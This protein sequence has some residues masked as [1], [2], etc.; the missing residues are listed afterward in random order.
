MPEGY[1]RRTQGI[2]PFVRV[3]MGESTC[4]DSTVTL[5]VTWI[6]MLGYPPVTC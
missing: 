1:L 6:Y 5:S 4:S 2:R 3:D